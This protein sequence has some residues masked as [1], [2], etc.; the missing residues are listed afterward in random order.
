MSEGKISHVDAHITIKKGLVVWSTIDT[1]DEKT[2][3]DYDNF[4]WYFFWDFGT[5]SI[6]LLFSKILA[7]FP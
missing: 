5:L 6:M 4:P 1:A 2:R 3:I 7:L